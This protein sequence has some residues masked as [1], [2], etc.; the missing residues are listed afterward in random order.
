MYFLLLK[1]NSNKLFREDFF[2]MCVRFNTVFTL[3]KTKKNIY[4]TKKKLTSNQKFQKKINSL[5]F[6]LLLSFIKKN[7][8]VKN[9]C[10]RT[11][12]NQINGTS[13]SESSSN[14]LLKSSFESLLASLL[15]LLKK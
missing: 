2:Q 12:K 9:L 3:L 4:L 11:T 15:E 1:K 6:L 14:I 8:N 7:K 10:C 5:I 13:L